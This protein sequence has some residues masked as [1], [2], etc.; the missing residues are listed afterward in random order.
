MQ[1][2]DALDIWK[3]DITPPTHTPP[4]IAAPWRHYSISPVQ[5]A[6]VVPLPCETLSASFPVLNRQEHYEQ[7]TYVL[8]DPPA[9][10]PW[11]SGIR[12]NVRT[13]RAIWAHLVGWLAYESAEQ[14]EYGVSSAMLSK[15]ATTVQ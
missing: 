7:D 2:T 4:D 3:N 6:D 14:W 5:S 1:L 9:S 15:A 13:H 10:Q 11:C 8:S 12:A